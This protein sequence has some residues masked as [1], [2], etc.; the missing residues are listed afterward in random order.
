MLVEIHVV[1][2]RAHDL[3]DARAGGVHEF[4]QRT[5][6]HQHGVLH[7]GHART[8]GLRDGLQQTG[9]LVHGQHVGQ[10]ARPPWGP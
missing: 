6:S 1:D 8:P 4:E 3:R 10:R 5:V 7:T 2:I 9:D